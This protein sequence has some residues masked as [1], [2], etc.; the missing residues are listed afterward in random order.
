MYTTGSQSSHWELDPVFRST[1]RS[2]CVFPTSLNQMEEDEKSRTYSLLYLSYLMNGISHIRRRN[3]CP[4]VSRYSYWWRM[5]HNREQKREL[6]IHGSHQKF[7][8]WTK[9]FRTRNVQE[10][11]MFMRDAFVTWPQVFNTVFEN[12]ANTTNIG[13]NNSS[14]ADFLLDFL[15]TLF[16]LDWSWG[17]CVG[18]KAMAFNVFPFQNLVKMSSTKSL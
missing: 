17:D 2:R 14:L 7:C 9:E 5:D 11:H 1:S 8:N 6:D 4:W 13:K 12:R 3:S 18:I 15:C 10:I 16:Q